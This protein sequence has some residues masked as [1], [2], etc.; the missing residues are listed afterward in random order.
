M[1]NKLKEVESYFSGDRIIELICLLV[2]YD[3]PVLMLGK[4]SIGKSFTIISLAKK[5]KLPNQLLY[6]GSEKSEHI[7]GLPKLVGL[8]EDRV[9]LEYLQ[10]YWFPD[11]KVIT[12]IVTNGRNLFNDF[13]AN[14]YQ[15]NFNYSYGVLSKILELFGEKNFEE[16]KTTLDVDL[17]DRKVP[18]D[19]TGM[20]EVVYTKKTWIAQREI[21][22]KEH[23]GYYHDDLRDICVYLCTLLGYGNFWLI[24]DEIDKVEETDV[25]KF[26]PL[27]HIVRERWLKKWKLKPLNE[28]KGVEINKM[29]NNS[30]YRAIKDMIDINIT[31]KQPLLDTRVIAIA[32]KTGQLE[33]ALF[34]RFCQVIISDPLILDP[35][36]IEVGAV[37]NCIDKKL[38]K[39]ILRE[40]FEDIDAKR[41][42][43]INLQWI[44]NFFPKMLNER[45]IQGNYIIQD[46]RNV[47]SNNLID[48][49]KDYEGWKAKKMDLA[50]GT[51]LYKIIS[52]NYDNDK[53]ELINNLFDCL[54]SQIDI[55]QVGVGKGPREVAEKLIND[56]RKQKLDIYEQRDTIIEI[57]DKNYPAVVKE[58][59]ISELERWVDNCTTYLDVTMFDKGEFAQSELSKILIPSI[60]RLI[61]DK[62]T[63]DKSLN[64][65][66]IKAVLSRVSKYWEGVISG[67]P[68]HKIKINAEEVQRVLYG[69]TVDKLKTMK[70]SDKILISKGSVFGAGE[71]ISTDSEATSAYKN[72]LSYAIVMK[73]TEYLW[74]V[75]STYA[76][77][78]A[79]PGKA[80]YYIKDIKDYQDI[81]DFPEMIKFIKDNQ[82]PILSKMIAKLKS[83]RHPKFIDMAAQ[84]EDILK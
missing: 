68:I 53:S 42:D 29:V 13:I 28:G 22:G 83:G 81:R 80:P 34:R 45:D 51:L 67:V 37:K 49:N 7:E 55:Q 20:K 43:D 65:D 8:K 76:T 64:I 54:S 38:D 82:M 56:M 41:I 71:Y 58:G 59:D 35:L 62:I 9:T 63:N 2:R 26:A 31:I 33:D 15:G 44:L 25:D 48:P 19:R 74:I 40:G 69:E 27:L 61:Y 77:N 32:N 46:Y 72:S 30:D 66:N 60:Q 11:E 39:K 6:V 12:Q 57:L 18:L 5:W 4:S 10:P 17:V 75:L 70:N 78:L 50:A 14:Y 84:I 73:Q 16:G 36:D 52:D 21:V 47:M 79:A 3:I 1:A 23:E 24:L